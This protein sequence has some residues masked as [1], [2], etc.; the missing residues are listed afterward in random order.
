M[1][2]LRIRSDSK[3]SSLIT[4]TQQAEKKHLQMIHLETLSEEKINTDS[5]CSPAEHT[6]NL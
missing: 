2:N 3:L 5:S 1:F 4:V 6:H